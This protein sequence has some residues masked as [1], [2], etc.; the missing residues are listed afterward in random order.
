[1][2]DTPEVFVTV[3]P[4][5]PPEEEVVFS[6]AQQQKLDA[7][8]KKAMGRAGS[9]ARAEAERLRIENERLKEVAAGKGSDD[10]IEKIRGEL[11]SARLEADALRE[12]SIASQ[13]DLLIAS[14][15]AA[16]HD[17]DVLQKLT[18]SN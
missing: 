13:R 2:S 4:D 12:Q 1:M 6:P 18:R 10:Q 15:G 5:N 16:F 8:L 17:I 7:I 14:Q 9:D 11:A 3:L